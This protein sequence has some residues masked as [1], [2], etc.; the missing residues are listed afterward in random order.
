MKQAS[1]RGGVSWPALISLTLLLLIPAYAISRL[2]A[3][4]D[5]RILVGV[6]LVVSLGTFVAYR[7]D[8]RRAQAGEWRVPESTLHLA[9]LAGGWPGAFLAQ[10]TFRHKTSKVSYQVVFWVIVL[11]YQLV[12]LDSL[13]GWRFTKEVLHLTRQPGNWE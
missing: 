10:R 12:A 1:R 2:A 9:E 11:S 5:W 8:K 3:S 7:S 6:P 13:L 4:V